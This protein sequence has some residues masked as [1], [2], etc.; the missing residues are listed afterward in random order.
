[1]STRR[2][3]RGSM[4]GALLLAVAVSTG[5]SAA[6]ADI[7]FQ[8][9]LSIKNRYVAPYHFATRDG[10]VGVSVRGNY[11]LSTSGA[12]TVWL[13]PSL[14]R[15]VSD[16]KPK[17]VGLTLGLDWPMG[18]DGL[19]T[20]KVA[21]DDQPRT[22]L[23]ADANDTLALSIGYSQKLAR[24]LWLSL[25]GEATYNVTPSRVARPS[26]EAGV[27]LGDL[28]LD[29]NRCLA[30]SSTSLFGYDTGTTGPASATLKTG[31]ALAATCSSKLTAKLDAALEGRL[32]D[33]QLSGVAFNIGFALTQS[34]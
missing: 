13:E 25:S 23:L 22:T 16:F 28:Y 30:L 3:P 11:K 19:W 2:T 15:G 20:V 14:N 27:I 5:A 6:A 7:G 32:A 10:T 1:M 34:F 26:V 24:P 33:Q 9:T 17:S 29:R 4:L 18:A 12:G 8:A 31:V 21:Y